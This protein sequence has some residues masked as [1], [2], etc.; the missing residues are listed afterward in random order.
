LNRQRL[1]Q[2]AAIVALRE[3]IAVVAMPRRVVVLA[4]LHKD[5]IF[6]DGA[7]NLPFQGF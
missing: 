6:A 3:L 2:G 1:N 7:I 4:R 5:D